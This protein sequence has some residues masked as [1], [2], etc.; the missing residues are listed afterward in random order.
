SQDEK[1]NIQQTENWQIDLFPNP[2]SNRVT[3]KSSIEKDNLSI[4]I[5]DLTGRVLVSQQI[6]TENY[7]GFVDLH[8]ING[9]Y[10]TT[11]T[12][13]HGKTISKKLLIAK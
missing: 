10:I 13:E 3:V 6:I 12:N 5:C 11:I 7:I 1:L 8:L 9:A 2:T 4:R